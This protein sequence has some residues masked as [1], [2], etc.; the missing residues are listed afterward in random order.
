MQG[1]T[2]NDFRME[3]AGIEPINENP[4]TSTS[5]EQTTD[6]ESTSQNSISQIGNP[7]SHVG[8]TL[9]NPPC[10][11]GVAPSEALPAD[12]QALV[13]VWPE[14]PDT[15]KVGIIAMIKTVVCK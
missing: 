10:C 6:T 13:D 4:T 14:L 15:L 7:V 12:L 2:C 11:T 1:H 8:N 5:H 9:E 3:A